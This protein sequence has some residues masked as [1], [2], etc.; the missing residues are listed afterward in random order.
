M[1]ETE[2]ELTKNRN[3]ISSCLVDGYRMDIHSETNAQQS[4]LHIGRQV[5]MNFV[6]PLHSL[7]L[8]M[9]VMLES[10]ELEESSEKGTSFRW[11]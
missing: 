11:K 8:F 2:M 6:F 5:E 4:V 7:L 3:Q 9:N 10:L 1:R